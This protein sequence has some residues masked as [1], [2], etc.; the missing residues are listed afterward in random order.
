MDLLLKLNLKKIKKSGFSNYKKKALRLIYDKPK[1]Y[2]CSYLFKINN[3][4]TF[5]SLF[6]EIAIIIKANNTY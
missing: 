2:S 3:I 4:L 1:V 6:L 5:P